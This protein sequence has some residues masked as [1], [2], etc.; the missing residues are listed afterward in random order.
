MCNLNF[1]ITS[2]SAT[3]ELKLT[4]VMAIHSLRSIAS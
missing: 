3:I 1:V 2:G 4:F